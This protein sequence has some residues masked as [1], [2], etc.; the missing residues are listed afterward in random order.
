M[1]GEFFLSKKDVEQKVEQIVLEII[2]DLQIELV[3]VEYV[4]EGQWYLRIF[5]D[6]DGGIE[7]D[8]CQ[9]ISE[10]MTDILDEQDF[11]KES[12]YLEVSSPGLDRKLRKERDFVKHKGQ[13]VEVKIR[14]E[15]NI[16]VGILGDFSDEFMEFI[17]DGEPKQV[18]RKDITSIRLHLDF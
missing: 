5:L 18:N 17:V 9:S 11:I 3:D 12:Y 1:E 7:I 16:L 4:R 10:R 15:K 13:I 14:K 2:K 8:D 6:K